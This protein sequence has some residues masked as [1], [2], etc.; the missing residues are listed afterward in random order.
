MADDINQKSSVVVTREE[1]YRQVWET[2]MNRL[3]TR[4]GITGN[5]LAKIC[6][7]LR[8]PYPPRGYWA[9]KAAGQNVISYQLSP[10]GADT[11]QSVRINPTEPRPKPLKLPEE[12]GA[13][14]EEARREASSTAVPDRLQRPHPIIAH[15]LAEHD[16]RKRE[17]RRE[18]DPWLKQ[19]T[20]PGDF[21]DIDHRKHRILDTL[22][23]ASEKQGGKAREADRGILYVEMQGEKVEFQ[24][25]EK[26]KKGRRVLSDSEQ[27]WAG[28]DDKGWRQA[29]QP[30][31]KLTLVIKTYLPDGLQTE[32]I[33]TD[34]RSLEAWLPDIVAIFVAAGPLLVEQRRRR[35]AVEL[36]RQVAERRRYEEEQRR[37]LDDN[38]WRR[39]TEIAQQQRDYDL[40]GEFLA[41]IK[42]TN[43]DVHLQA[44]DRDVAAWIEWA[45]KCISEASPLA[46]GAQAIFHSVSQV[47]TYTY[48][49]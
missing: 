6:E 36:E 4:Y 7:R 30:T 8:V 18:R 37:K 32:W 45:E 19:L 34:D 22:F 5:G 12:L 20:D 24:L 33:E 40:A 35:E 14:I 21:S 2:P 47:Q 10:A 44:G 49:D 23:K 1:L 39:F 16:R 3:G 46:C 13:K 27:K 29:M 42:A 28:K 43:S 9:K 41:A 17:A 15:W 26:Q 31:G 25:R 11:P 48:R 38:R